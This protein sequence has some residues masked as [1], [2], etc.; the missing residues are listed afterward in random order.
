MTKRSYAPNR[1]RELR[2]AKGLSLEELGARMRSELTASTVFKLENSKMG[3]TLDYLNEISDVLG[4]PV[5]EVVGVPSG[6]AGTRLLPVVPQSGL[7]S[8]RDIVTV[9]KDFAAVSDHLSGENLF[10]VRPDG[11][12]AARICRA[13]GLLVIDPDQTELIAGQFYAVEA[14]D[15]TAGYAEFSTSPLQL[16]LCDSEAS[17]PVPIGSLAFTVIGRIVFT[18]HDL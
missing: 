4:I 5:N 10:V 7:G 1:I 3:L 12:S 18:G 11:S 13:G 6:A 16:V 15:G 2:I 9:T 17:M 8:W 14:A